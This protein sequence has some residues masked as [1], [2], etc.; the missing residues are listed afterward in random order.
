[1]LRRPWGVALVFRRTGYEWTILSRHWSRKRADRRADQLG[2]DHP[3]LIFPV[4][5]LS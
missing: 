1:M 5:K 4:R 2:H 3:F